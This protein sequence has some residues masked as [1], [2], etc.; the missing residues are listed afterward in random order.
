MH[1][2]KIKEIQ[3]GIIIL[4]VTFI[5]FFCSGIDLNMQYSH[6][7]IV[8]LTSIFLLM[9]V[10]NLRLL[11]EIPHRGLLVLTHKQDTWFI[12]TFKMIFFIIFFTVAT[13][14]TG[15]IADSLKFDRS[16]DIF[17]L[18]MFSICIV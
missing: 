9:L 13:I 2:L 18:S 12:S 8:L 7:F 14:I 1:I 5:S 17:L 4:I 11:V 3:L 16:Q 6:R 15:L 10:L